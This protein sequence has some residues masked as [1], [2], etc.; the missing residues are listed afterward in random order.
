V[1]VRSDEHQDAISRLDSALAKKRAPARASLGQ[2]EEAPRLDDAVLSEHHHR[3]PLRVVSERLH[4]VPSEVKPVRDLPASVR[5]GGI[6][7]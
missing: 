7:R 2:L 1:D 6:E 5:E 3:L 4:D